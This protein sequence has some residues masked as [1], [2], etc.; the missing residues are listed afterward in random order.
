M[1]NSTVKP[2]SLI[3]LAL[4]GAMLSAFGTASAADIQQLTAT[5]A[6]CHGENGA[7][8]S[9]PNYPILAGQYADY[10]AHALREYR[11]GKRKN[12]IMGAQAANLSDEDIEA[13]AA[14][15]A[16]QQGPLYTPALPKAK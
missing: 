10:L 4:L 14:Y 8:P 6:A 12:V 16:A 3:R 11:S 15:F 13:L 7:K 5:C 2:S 9:A 1:R